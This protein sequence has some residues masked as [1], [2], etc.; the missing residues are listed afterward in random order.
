MKKQISKNKFLL[1]LLIL[2]ST[3][4][5]FELPHKVI[6]NGY[7]RWNSNENKVEENSDDS[8]EKNDE[9]SKSNSNL[10]ASITSDKSKKLTLKKE[11]QK[12]KKLHKTLLE[13]Y[14][15]SFDNE[16]LKYI[17]NNSLIL[18]WLKNE[19]LSLHWD[20]NIII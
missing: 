19:Y 10:K 20:K 7:F 6:I 1:V 9:L 8:N 17:T 13:S 11:I 18:N 14:N 5:T 2:I 3:F 4:A 15:N 12:R 16:T